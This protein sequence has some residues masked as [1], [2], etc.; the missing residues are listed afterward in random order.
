MHYLSATH[1]GGQMYY[2]FGFLLLAF[3][4]LVVVS[5]QSS[6]LLCYFH[7]CAEDYRWWWRSFFSTGLSS[8]ISL[9]SLY[10]LIPFC[11]SSS[12]SLLPSTYSGTL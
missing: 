12:L 2:M 5:A 7:L 4:V 9:S 6:I 3:V 8:L 11:Y 1:R 10:H